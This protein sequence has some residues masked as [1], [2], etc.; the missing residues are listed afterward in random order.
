MSESSGQWLKGCAFGCGGLVVLCVLTIVG[1]SVS[2][3]SA[4][5][6]AHVDRM[7]LVEQFG[8]DDAFVPAVDGSVAASRVEAFLAVREALTQVHAEIEAVDREMGKMEALDDGE[9]PSMREALPLVF[10]LTKSMMG[11]PWIFGEIER[12]RNRALVENGMGL[13]EYTYIFV[14]A[15]HDQIVHPSGETVMFGS[16]PA[17]ARVRESLRGMAER[18]LAAAESEEP[19]DE[20]LVAVL[21]AELEALDSDAARVLWQDGLPESVAAS[22]AG[23]R[24]RLDAAYSAAAAELELLNSSV[25]AGGLRI[26]MN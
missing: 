19:P 12:T 25:E 8:G 4:F 3:R 17:G 18:Q 16:S 5:D 1:M 11:L 26:E 10:R 2:M 24:D 14:M 22:F 7:T 15:Y 13:G 23:F 21:A 6:D 9:E 20:A